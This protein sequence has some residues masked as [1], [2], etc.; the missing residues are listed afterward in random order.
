VPSVEASRSPEVFVRLVT[1]TPIHSIVVSASLKEG[2]AR[3]W[4][5]SR[6]SMTLAAWRELDKKHSTMLD[7]RD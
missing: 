6:R 1:S 2:D 3:T 7:H 5:R 4:R